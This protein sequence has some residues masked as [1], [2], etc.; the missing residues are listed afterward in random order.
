[1]ST[2]STHVLDTERGEPAA[3]VEVLLTTAE[4][5]ETEVTDTDGRARFARSVAGRVQLRFAT[6]ARSPF[7]A[8]VIL[9]LDL[10]PAREHH[11][12]PLLLS[13]F[14]CTTYRGS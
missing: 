11:H 8:A 12:V 7:L 10:D 5:T 9:D 13:S 6:A 14:G 3:G 2:L 4:G 1:M